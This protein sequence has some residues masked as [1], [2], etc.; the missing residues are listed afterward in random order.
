MSSTEWYTP[1][2][3]WQSLGIFDLDPC[4]NKKTLCHAALNWYTKEDDGL[5]QEWFGR[6]WLN[7]PYGRDMFKTWLKKMAE[8][9]NGIA[10]IP[11]RTGTAGFHNQVFNRGHSVFFFEGRISFILPNG[12]PMRGNDHDSVLVAY[13][14]FDTQAI[15]NS[16]LKGKVLKI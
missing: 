6:V 14:E 13:S 15:L 4:S 2:P 9:G 10:L 7:P 3:I 12:K 8:H 5:K 16:G 11:S 1:L